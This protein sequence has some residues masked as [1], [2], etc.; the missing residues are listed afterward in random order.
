MSNSQLFIPNKIKVGYQERRETYS[1]KLAYIIYFDNKGVLRKETSWNGW[2]DKKLGHNEFENVPIEGFVLN[3]KAGGY[4][5]GWNHRQTY[6]RVWDPR[7]FEF[8]INITNLLFILQETSCTKGKGLEGEFVYAWEG[9]DLVLLPAHCE[10]YKQSQQFTKLQDSKISTKD[11]IPGCIYKTK[12]EQD[13]T[14]LGKFNW[15]NEHWSDS[16][17]VSISNSYIFVG[18]NGYHMNMS[19]LSTIAKRVT[20]EPVTDYAEKLEIF[21]KSNNSGQ[22]TRISSKDITFDFHLKQYSSYNHRYIYSHEK[23]EEILEK[24]IKIPGQFALKEEEN[25]YRLYT[26]EA[27]L[28]WESAYPGTNNTYYKAKI[29]GYTIN[30]SKLLTM[31]GEEL[32]Y[33]AKPLKDSKL[34]SKEEIQKIGFQEITIN[35]KL[36]DKEKTRILDLK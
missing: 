26:I 33:K 35:Y 25:L 36:K 9:K 13:V 30:S 2:C 6:C 32:V 7:G 4:S 8:E 27:N 29:I 19:S 20:D 1:G 14:Y 16:K 15:V 23:S 22:I 28:E 18:S 11:L 17:T 10:E 21:A 5:T 12:H 34:Y 3:K 24:T 31:K